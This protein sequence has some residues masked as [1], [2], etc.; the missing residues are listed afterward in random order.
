MQLCQKTPERYYKQLKNF[1]FAW[2]QTL[3]ICS[4]LGL[5]FNHEKK[6]RFCKKNANIPVLHKRKFLFWRDYPNLIKNCACHI[7]EN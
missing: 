4:L 7:L 5:I 3:Q 2:T 6:K 1:L